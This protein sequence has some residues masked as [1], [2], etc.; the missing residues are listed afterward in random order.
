MWGPIRPPAPGGFGF[1]ILYVDDYSRFRQVYLM[2][3]KS[4]AASTLEKYITAFPAKRQERIQ[5]IR[6]DSAVE[7]T[8]GTF[9]QLCDDKAIT[10][11][12]SAPYNQWQNG[13]AERSWRTLGDKTRAMMIASGLPPSF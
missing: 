11:E 2:K 7:Y 6:A 13:V 1:A 8:L 10:Q 5:R 12:F 4:E 9:K 3:R